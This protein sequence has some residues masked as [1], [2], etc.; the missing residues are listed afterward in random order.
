MAKA[1]ESLGTKIHKELLKRN[2]SQSDLARH[3]WPGETIID[4]RGYTAPKGRDRV[5]AWLADKQVPQPAM[6]R[7]IAE[8]LSFELDELSPNALASPREKATPSLSITT[9]ASAPDRVLLQVNKLLPLKA[10]LEIA[11]IVEKYEE[12]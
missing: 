12:K 11:A 9:L 10:A 1:A 6:L 8:V 7:R 2:W 3:L 5:S 4:S